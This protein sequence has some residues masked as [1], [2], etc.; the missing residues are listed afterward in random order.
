MAVGDAGV[1]A[2]LPHKAAANFAF[3][4]EYAAASGGLL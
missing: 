3:H 4:D 2:I 1:P